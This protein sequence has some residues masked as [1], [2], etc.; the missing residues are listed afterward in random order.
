MFQIGVMLSDLKADLFRHKGQELPLDAVDLL[1]VLK[2]KVS[3]N[4][5]LQQAWLCNW[6]QLVV[7]LART[8][9][10]HNCI[11]VGQNLVCAALYDHQLHCIDSCAMQMRVA[12]CF[13]SLQIAEMSAVGTTHYFAKQLTV[14]TICLSNAV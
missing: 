11:R 1:Q 14:Q 12:Q 9:W 3:A 2:N 10:K 5:A 13:T 8:S 6:E 7:R 4:E